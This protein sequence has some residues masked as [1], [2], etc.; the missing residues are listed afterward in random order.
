ME[1]KSQRNKKIYKKT[2]RGIRGEVSG[3]ASGSV[4]E[5]VSGQV[6][7]ETAGRKFLRELQDKFQSYL[8]CESFMEKFSIS[9]QILRDS[10]GNCW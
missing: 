6:L 5:W 1:K 9:C 10:C 2:Y 3:R 8:L 7:M 4:P